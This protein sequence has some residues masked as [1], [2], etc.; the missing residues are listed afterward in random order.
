MAHGPFIFVDPDEQNLDLM[1]L[2]T[3]DVDS[4]CDLLRCDATD[5]V[6]LPCELMGYLDG[7]G[8]W[9]GRQTEWELANASYW[10]PMLI[11]KDFDEVGL[12]SSCDEEDLE[13][14][15]ALIHFWDE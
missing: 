1:E 7:E 5:V 4:L 2:D 3:L 8:A 10:G 9:Q 13:N 6:E 11:F 15:G 14:L 12:P